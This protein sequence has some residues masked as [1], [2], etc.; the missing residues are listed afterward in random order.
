MHVFRA[1]QYLNGHVLYGQ[2]LAN[3]MIVLS[4]G[5]WVLPYWREKGLCN[6]GAKAYAGVLISESEGS[7]WQSYGAISHPN[8]ALREN[9][10]VDVNGRLLMYFR[11]TAGSPKDCVCVAHVPR[12]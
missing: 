12:V 6:T 5:D 10:V 11:Y 1:L 8:T 3:K 4:N 9:S 2:V 7:A